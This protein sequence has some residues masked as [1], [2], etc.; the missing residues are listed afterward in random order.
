VMMGSNP[1]TSWNCCK[2]LKLERVRKRTLESY[3]NVI[4]MYDFICNFTWKTNE[5]ERFNNGRTKR[6]FILVELELSV[7]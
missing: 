5:C 2:N 7:P 6:T 1:P 3:R 4:W